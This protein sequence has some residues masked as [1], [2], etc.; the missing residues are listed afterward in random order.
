LIL[1]LA[2]K[3]FILETIIMASGNGDISG[4]K[5]EGGTTPANTPVAEGVKIDVAGGGDA[6]NPTTTS[7]NESAEPLKI[8]PE[9]RSADYQ[10]LIQCGLDEK[11]AAKLDDIYNT[12]NFQT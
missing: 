4:L 7:S 11:V 5:E 6:F 2:K 10:K 12:G 1:S 8:P 3:E 9:Q